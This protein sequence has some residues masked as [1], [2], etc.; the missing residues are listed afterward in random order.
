M[1]P[2]RWK[3]RRLFWKWAQ[4]TL[5]A[6]ESHG[7]KLQSL[8]ASPRAGQR[9]VPANRSAVPRRP[10][11]DRYSI[12]V[13]GSG[14]PDTP[15]VAQVSS[16]SVTRGI[17]SRRLLNPCKLELLDATTRRLKEDQRNESLGSISCL[18]RC[19]GVRDG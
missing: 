9:E 11:H 19:G 3:A 17:A 2:R 15:L 10:L 4:Y 8:S 5:I 18:P 6:A 1:T 16:V 12:R 7:T 13:P 14:T